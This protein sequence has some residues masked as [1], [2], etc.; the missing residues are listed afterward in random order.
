[1]VVGHKKSHKNILG[2]CVRIILSNYNEIQV[3]YTYH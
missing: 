2:F 3:E 1:M